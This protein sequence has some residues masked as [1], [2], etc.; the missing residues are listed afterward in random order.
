MIPSNIDPN[1]YFMKARI[2]ILV[3]K[4]R[5]LEL[6]KN[7][8]ESIEKVY[9]N[10]KS[11]KIC[12]LLIGGASAGKTTLLNVLL[13]Y[14]LQTNSFDQN[15][16]NFLQTDTM[17]NTTFIWVIE[18]SS[19][20][21]LSLQVDHE[22]PISYEKVN[23]MEN[24]TDIKK[25]IQILNEEQKKEVDNM[26]SNKNFK[27]KTILIK[28][29]NFDSTI[30]IIDVAGLSCE[31][32]QNTVQELITTEMACIFY[33]KDLADVEIIKENVIKFISQFKERTKTKKIPTHQQHFL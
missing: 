25:Y 12:I 24:M 7:E 6:I 3:A 19:N 27:Q 23:K 4:I 18:S 26:K 9:Q 5:R 13:S 10:F 2:E 15:F 28:V 17:E 8:Q 16:F 22:N 33:V 14:D 20:G 11:G 30:R 31:S 21:Y 29:P 1:V 32:T